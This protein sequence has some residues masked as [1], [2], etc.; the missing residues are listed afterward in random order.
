MYL[1]ISPRKNFARFVPS[2]GSAERRQEM[3]DEA[4][5]LVDALEREL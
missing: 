4:G 5:R 2:S 3:L 1:S